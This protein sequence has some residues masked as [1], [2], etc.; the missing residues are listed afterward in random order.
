MS[1]TSRTALDRAAA[2]AAQAYI[3][4]VLRD[5][6]A[7]VRGEGELDEALA[8]ALGWE[9]QAF[10][11][12][13]FARP[14]ETEEWEV[15]PA[16]T[17]DFGRAVAAVPRDRYFRLNNSRRVFIAQVLDADVLVEA[18]TLQQ[19]TG[20]TPALALWGAILKDHLQR[21]S[22]DPRRADAA[23]EAAR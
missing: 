4:Q 7:A 22:A 23:A 1:D 17:A 15:L 2:R 18:G 16:L 13:R 12:V 3:E 8:R 14:C 20:H 21:L 9:L 11:G 5:L 10:G 6:G 19:S